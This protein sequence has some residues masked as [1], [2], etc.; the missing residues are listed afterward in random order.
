MITLA[1]ETYSSEAKLPLNTLPTLQIW[2]FN[3]VSLQISCDG[4]RWDTFFSPVTQ[5]EG[6]KGNSVL[7]NLYPLLIRLYH[8]RNI[9][10]DY[11]GQ[12]YYTVIIDLII[13]SLIINNCNIATTESSLATNYWCLDP[14]PFSLSTQ[15]AVG[16]RKGLTWWNKEQSVALHSLQYILSAVSAKLHYLMLKSALS[17]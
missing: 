7:W 1:R 6:C 17:I 11:S 15:Y 9:G 14:R 10:L 5:R 13:I 8:C 2:N 4:W 16:Y 12:L 3:L